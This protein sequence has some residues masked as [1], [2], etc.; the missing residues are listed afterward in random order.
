MVTVTR[1]RARQGD[2]SIG[3][4]A[5]T[6]WMIWPTPCLPRTKLLGSLASQSPSSLGVAQSGQSTGLGIRESLVRIQP[7]RPRPRCIQGRATA[8]EE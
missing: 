3:S 1:A 2:A 4:G 5:T 7:P 8:Y 6:G